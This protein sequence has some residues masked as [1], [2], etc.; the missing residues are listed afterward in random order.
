MAEIIPSKTQ[1]PF[2]ACPALLFW[3]GL[4]PLGSSLGITKNSFCNL[5]SQ[6]QAYDNQ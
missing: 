6:S 1:V 5:L 2:P 4:G 3:A